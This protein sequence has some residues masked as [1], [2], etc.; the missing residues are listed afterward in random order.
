MIQHHLVIIAIL[1]I[2]LAKL[3]QIGASVG[4]L[5]EVQNGGQVSEADDE[6]KLDVGHFIDESCCSCLVE[7][8]GGQ[9]KYSK[10]KD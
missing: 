2:R 6:Y 3:K 5:A 1:S 10:E 7:R 9:S 4:G 8:N